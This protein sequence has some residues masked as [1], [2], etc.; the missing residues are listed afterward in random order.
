LKSFYFEA[1]WAVALAT[2]L[3]Y[4]AIE[5]P[6]AGV[7]STEGFTYDEAASS[8]Q[9][10]NAVLASTGELYAAWKIG[11]DNC[12]AG[13]LVDRSVRYPINKPRADCGAGKPGVHTVY[14]HPNQT[15]VSEL[16]AR[17]DAYCFRGTCLV[18]IYQADL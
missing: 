17:F 14:S 10:H 7:F 6:I 11:F 9:E 5:K 1:I 8:C 12:H 15:N 2:L 16:D 13:W 4:H 18:V 3:Q